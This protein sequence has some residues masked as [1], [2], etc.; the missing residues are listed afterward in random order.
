MMASQLLKSWRHTSMDTLL[1]QPGPCWL[2]PYDHTNTLLTNK[3]TDVTAKCQSLNPVVSYLRPSSIGLR[4]DA[5]LPT[6]RIAVIAFPYTTIQEEIIS[7]IEQALCEAT[8]SNH[9][10]LSAHGVFV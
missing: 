10:R 2:M 3:F 1:K 7:T 9:I 8:G 4:D 5:Y 6:S